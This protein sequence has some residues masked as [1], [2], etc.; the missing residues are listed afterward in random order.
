MSLTYF[1]HLI[2]SLLRKQGAPFGEENVQE[3][4]VHLRSACVCL[5]PGS[6]RYLPTNLQGSVQTTRS[7]SWWKLTASRSAE[8]PF[9]A[10]ELVIRE[11]S[12][13]GDVVPVAP[14]TWREDHVY[15]SARKAPVKPSLFSN[16]N[17][18]CNCVKVRT[19]IHSIYCCVC[20]P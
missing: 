15:V 16:P 20:M 10:N 2:F 18:S 13:L 14:P 1:V 3:E 8:A 17:V 9:E 19:L 7:C 6:A 5:H 4:G 12:S 11:A